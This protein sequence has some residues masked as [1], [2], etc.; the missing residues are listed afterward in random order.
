MPER[1]EARGTLVEARSDTDVQIVRLTWVGRRGCF[2][3]PRHGIESSK[4]AIFGK[5]N[6]RCGMNRKPGYGAQLRA[7]LEPTKGVGRLRQQDGGHGSRNPLRSVTTHLPNQLAP[8]WMAL[9]RATYTRP[10]GQV[11]GP[12]E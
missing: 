2:V 9:K 8:K 1:G 6:W 12:D 10:S 4:W 3:E 7:N 11:P 5:Q